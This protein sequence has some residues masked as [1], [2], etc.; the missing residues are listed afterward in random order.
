[1]L[2]ESKSASATLLVKVAK[3]RKVNVYIDDP[4]KMNK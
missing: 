2:T 4:E 1:M 3:M